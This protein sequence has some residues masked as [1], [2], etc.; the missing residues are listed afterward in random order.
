[1]GLRHLGFVIRTKGMGMP[2]R[3]GKQREDRGQLSQLPMRRTRKK[4]QR[5]RNEDPSMRSNQS[6]QYVS[7]RGSR[8]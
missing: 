8:N 1:M 7:S 3:L 6:R 5:G 4:N 2:D